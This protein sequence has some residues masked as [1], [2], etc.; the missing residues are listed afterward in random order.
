MAPIWQNI[1]FGY[2]DEY[3]IYDDA[4]DVDD[5]KDHGDGGQND[6]AAGD[7]DADDDDDDDDRE[8][9]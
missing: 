6:Y 2:G 7:H 4:A 1:P 9:R 5:E 3:I 8:R